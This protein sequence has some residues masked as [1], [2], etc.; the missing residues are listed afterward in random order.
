MAQ[1]GRQW[2]A[3][4]VLLPHLDSSQGAAVALRACG[5]VPGREG[6]VGFCMRPVLRYNTAAVPSKLLPSTGRLWRGS[7]HAGP[8]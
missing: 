8:T 6:A 4:E 7:S 5:R 1:P 2:L 3:G